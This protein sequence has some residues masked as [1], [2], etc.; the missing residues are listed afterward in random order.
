M[1]R[2]RKLTMFTK[3]GN[4]KMQFEELMED[5][6]YPKIVKAGYLMS[7]QYRHTCSLQYDS[8]KDSCRICLVKRLG[9]TM[10]NVIYKYLPDVTLLEIRRALM[11]ITQS[12]SNFLYSLIKKKLCRIN[13]FSDPL[14][15]AC[16]SS[17]GPVTN[18]FPQELIH[19]PI[20]FFSFVSGLRKFKSHCWSHMPATIL[21]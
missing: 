7:F 20:R 9:D 11:K 4:L 3:T 12:S 19:G 16:F 13:N 18:G 17:N 6:Q 14:I 8:L 5:R 15:F 1:E 10:L 21:S 2:Q